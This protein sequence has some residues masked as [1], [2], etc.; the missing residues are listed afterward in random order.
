MFKLSIG[1]ISYNRPFELQRTIKSLL[2]LPVGVEVIICDDK[3]PR[4]NEIFSTIN[5]FIDNEKIRFVINETNLGYDENLFHVIELA[6]ADHVLLLGDDDYLEPGAIDNVL[7]F[8]GTENNIHCAFLRFGAGF[9]NNYNRNYGRNIYFNSKTIVNN[10]SFLYNSILFSGLIFAKKSVLDN[11]LI[12]RNYFRSIYIQVAIFSILNIE[13]GSFFIGGPG[14]IVGGD[15]ESGFGF[16][17]SSVG[18]DMDLKDRSSVISNLSYHKRLFDVINKLSND[19]Q[20]DI[21]SPFIS[22]YKIRSVKAFI[23][24]SKLGRKYLIKYFLE[25]N[26]LNVPGI[27]LFYPIYL[28]IFI[29][30]SI[31]LYK[32]L[33]FFEEILTSYRIRKKIK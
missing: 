7:N 17:E 10:G 1:I 19:I 22:E 6:N 2:P 32:P 27:L 13:Y 23:V 24:A 30:P 29:T 16:N 11:K 14:V 8:I 15:G 3:S 25:L 9:D 33:K 21:Y 4:L 18:L 28:L 26:K 20:I 12:L 31:F 5:Y